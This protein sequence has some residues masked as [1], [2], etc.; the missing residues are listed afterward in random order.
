MREADEIHQL[1]HAH[2]IGAAL[3]QAIG[4]ILDDPVPGLLAVALLVAHRLTISRR[5]DAVH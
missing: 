3:A 5:M 4:G 2:A 1:D